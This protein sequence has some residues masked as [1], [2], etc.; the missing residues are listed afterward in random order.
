MDRNRPSV[1]APP[2]LP[3]DQGWSLPNDDP[4]TAGGYEIAIDQEA[5]EAALLV[6]FLRYEH[7][8]EDDAHLLTPA[9]FYKLL[10]A[11]IHAGND[12]MAI[13][14][15]NRFL[16]AA[17]ASYSEADHSAIDENSLLQS[18]EVEI[19]KF[20]ESNE[21]THRLSVLG[22]KEAE[23]LT[24]VYNEQNLL[25]FAKDTIVRN[26]DGLTVD[27]LLVIYRF[28]TVVR[29]LQEVLEHCAEKELDPNLGTPKQAYAWAGRVREYGYDDEGRIDSDDYISF[30][31]QA[32]EE[33]VRPV[34]VENTELKVLLPR[35]FD[36]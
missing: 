12:D 35:K 8:L 22:E 26:Q 29:S 10:N 17:E 28:R 33:E 32:T 34:V 24:L 3:E 14:A 30:S 23:A 18:I 21:K 4:Q 5:P 25:A 1:E 11:T 6:Y 31:G 2:S 13:V 7:T 19:S 36:E 27:A 15:V 9:N 16:S 20:I